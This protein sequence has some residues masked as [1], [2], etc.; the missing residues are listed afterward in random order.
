MRTFFYG[1]INKKIYRELSKSLDIRYTI[2]SVEDIHKDNSNKDLVINNFNFDIN[3]TSFGQKNYKLFLKEN[4]DQFYIM[5]IRRG[6]N[7]SDY[8]EIK[9]EFTI[10][11]HSFLKILFDKKIQLIIFETLPH[12]GPDFILY[13]LAKLVGIKTLLLYQSIFPD[14]FFM[15]NDI[16]NFGKFKKKKFDEDFISAIL[17]QKY[18]YTNLIADL[19]KNNSN[20]YILSNERNY[21]KIS[22][23]KIV[24]ETLKFLKI[25]NR[26]NFEKE[27][28]E[29]I[30]IIQINR[31]ELLKILSSN[32]KKI[33]FPLQ[34]Q[35]E[36]TT[37]LLGYE[38]DDQILAIEKL[39]ELLDNK[40]VILVKENPNQSSYQRRN[41]FFKRLKYLK[42]L[43]FIDT[44]ID[45]R[46]IINNTD[47]TAT[48]T[49]TASW[50]ALISNKKCLVFGKSWNYLLHGCMKIDDNT[51]RYQL[52][53]FIKS[54]FNIQKFYND[55]NSLLKTTYKGVINNF[56]KNISVDYD[57]NINSKIVA[58]AIF[59]Y[60]KKFK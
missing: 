10:Y 29:N 58:E 54:E 48:I 28:L 9:N 24:I 57:D 30:K 3:L 26:K 37:S 13:K 20:K 4:F 25:I 11:Y 22:F 7:L 49:G 12:D 2:H 34:F 52:Q 55:L 33:Y 27:Y 14:R 39:S 46:Y 59:N 8:H 38:Y 53:K 6:L 42:N 44:K 21:L 41:F 51:T 50:E 40:W 17:D 15:I 1:I 18:L 56:Y 36:L 45:S 35:P 16:D 32:K 60:L 31:E 23:R 43:Y 47:L 19:R 5:I